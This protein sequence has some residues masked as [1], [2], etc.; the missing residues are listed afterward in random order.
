M[1]AIMAT[2]LLMVFASVILLLMAKESGEDY[3][4]MFW[5]GSCLECGRLH[6]LQF[7]I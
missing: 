5:L 4:T 2:L 7:I 6:F 3:D 1:F